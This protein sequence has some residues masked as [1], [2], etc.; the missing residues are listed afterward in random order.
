[1]HREFITRGLSE[2]IQNIQKK[3]QKKIPKKYQKNA[4]FLKTYT[5]H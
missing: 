4:F 3:I 2:L 5:K 1:M